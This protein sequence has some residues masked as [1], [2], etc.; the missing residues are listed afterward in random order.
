MPVFWLLLLLL[1]L[2]GWPSFYAPIDKE[3]IIEVGILPASKLHGSMQMIAVVSGLQLAHC[4][5]QQRPQQRHLHVLWV[6]SG[7][8]LLRL[9][10]MHGAVACSCA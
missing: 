8:F 5:Q 4:V 2:A 3:H 9:I 10:M 6:L 7:S 1:L